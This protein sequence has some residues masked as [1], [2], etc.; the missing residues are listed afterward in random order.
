MY[1]AFPRGTWYNSDPWGDL[2]AM[3]FTCEYCNYVFPADKEQRQCPDCGKFFL[4]LATEAEIAEY[5]QIE[6]EKNEHPV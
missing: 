1:I 3:M 6:A 5:E 2:R 4:R